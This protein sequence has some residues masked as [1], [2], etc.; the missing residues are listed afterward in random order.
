MQSQ[1]RFRSI[2]LFVLTIPAFAGAATPWRKDPMHRT[3][4][5]AIGE[6]A[7]RTGFAV[8]A[9][10]FYAA[11]GLIATLRSCGGQ[12]RFL[13][14]AIRRVSFILTLPPLCLTREESAL[15]L[16]RLPVKRK[17]NDP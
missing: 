12:R 7:A 4:V 10:R 2:G 16:A 13:R 17:P 15:E 5:I 6:L 11:K 3:D 1:V 14:A 8:S 9:I